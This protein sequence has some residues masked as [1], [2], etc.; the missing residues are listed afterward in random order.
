MEN[1]TREKIKYEC[2]YCGA[3]I[4]YGSKKAISDNDYN[5]FCSQECFNEYHGFRSIDW[6]SRREYYQYTRKEWQLIVE[7]LKKKSEQKEAEKEA[8]RKE[9]EPLFRHIDATIMDLVKEEPI[10]D[11]HNK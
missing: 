2:Q 8:K 11:T 5:D 6:Q 9:A 1:E 10:N 7:E 4:P 3:D